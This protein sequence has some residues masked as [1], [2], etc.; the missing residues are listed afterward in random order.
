MKHVNY[1]EK[2]RSFSGKTLYERLSEADRS[3]VRSIAFSLRLTFQEF[4]S[5]TEICRDMDMWQGISLKNFSEAFFKK[6]ANAT[7]LNKKG[8]LR[9]L[10]DY[11]GTLKHLPTEYSELEFPER[12]DPVPQIVISEDPAKNI[13][14]MCPVASEETVCCN[15]RT[16]D[17]VENCIY[18]CSYCT[19]QTFYGN[20]VTV[21][22]MLKRKLNAIPLDKGV[23]YHIGTGQ[24]SDSLAFGNLNGMLDT[25]MEFAEKHPDILLELKT[26]SANVGYFLEGNFPRNIV[27][28][29]S[30]NPEIIIRNEERLTAALSERLAAAEKVAREGIKVGFHF[31]PM[32]YFKGWEK[33]YT[34]IAEEIQQRFRSDQVLFISFG[35]VTLIKP[36]I[37]KIR[38]SGF[39]TKI[40]QMEMMPDPKGKPTYPD[41]VKVMMFRELY[42][43]F[44]DW[45]DTVFFY[46]CMEKASIWKRTFGFVYESNT[47]FEQEFGKQT[48]RKINRA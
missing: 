1:E 46:L 48:M 29:W 13:F 23:F 42:A 4:R 2:F 8:F 24:S 17:A 28:T 26:K 44:S 34:D 22:G 33:E 39:P 41:D 16:I 37:R 3:V 6:H 20:R 35:S 14:G 40:L 30:L 12:P 7:P 11:I 36:V 18:G 10:S 27:C 19:I 38:E 15:L 9:E 45:H 47:E 21:D 5:L 32:I 43:A 25:L 31:H